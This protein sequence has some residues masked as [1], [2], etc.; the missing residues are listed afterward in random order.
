MLGRVVGP[1]VFWSIWGGVL[2][3]SIWG[4]FPRVVGGWW[5]VL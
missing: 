3:W 2:V 5:G 1:R 4:G